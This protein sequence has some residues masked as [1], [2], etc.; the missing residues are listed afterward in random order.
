[1]AIYCGCCGG[2]LGGAQSVC[3]CGN[4]ADPGAPRRP[5]SPIQIASR[6]V[7]AIILIGGL[8]VAVSALFGHRVA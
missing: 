2:L 5:A 8:A 4:A 7:G 1:M 6:I 3:V